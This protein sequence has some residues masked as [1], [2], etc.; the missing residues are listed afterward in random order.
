MFIFNTLSIPVIYDYG[1]E[2][3]FWLPFPELWSRRTVNNDWFV[4]WIEFM[5]IWLI[6]TK[7]MSKSLSPFWIQNK[8]INKNKFNYNLISNLLS[9]NCESDGNTDDSWRPKN[10]ILE[11][12][13]ETNIYFEIH[14]LAIILLVMYWLIYSSY[15][16]VQ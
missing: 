11:T 1:K 14:F 7:F 8:N 15:S 4:D 10:V 16:Y 2:A 6:L 3:Y 9:F 12:R 5:W 13:Y